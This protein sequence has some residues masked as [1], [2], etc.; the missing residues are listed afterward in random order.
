MS[1]RAVREALDD[2]MDRSA[3]KVVTLTERLRAGAIDLAEWQLEMAR[4]VKGVH[5]ASAALAKG[6]WAQMS[7]SDILAAGRAIRLQ[8]G[9]LA[10]FAAEVASGEQLL[11]GT[12]TRRATMYVEAGRATYHATEQKEQRIRGAV[13]ERSIRSPVDSCDECISEEAKGWQPI[14]E[15]VPIG[16]RICLVKC[17]CRPEYR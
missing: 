4:T 5:L 15:M 7:Q 3:V 12:V 9:F 17:R 10:N 11:D 8:Y 13:E 16:A 1:Q 14:G 2:A 6:G